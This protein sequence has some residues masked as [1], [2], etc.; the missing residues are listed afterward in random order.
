M[1]I[2]IVSIFYIVLTAFF[3]YLAIKEKELTEKLKIK[4][5]AFVDKVLYKMNI[6]SETIHNR[7]KQ[8]FQTVTVLVTAFLLVLVIQRF[9]IGNFNIPTGSMIPTIELKDRVFGNMVKYKFIDPK[10]NEII[11]FKEPIENKNLYTKRIMALPG[12]TIKIRND[13]LIVDDKE[14]ETRRYSNLGIEDRVWIVPKKGDVLKIV[15]SGDYAAVFSQ[16]GFDIAD[17]Q[18][19]LKDNAYAVMQ[20]LPNLKFYVNDVET[21]PIFDFIHDK[22]IFEK[23]IH[24]ETVTLTLEENYFLALGDNTDESFD[25]RFWGF[26]GK[27]RIRGEVLFRFWPL[28]RMGIV[29]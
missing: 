18:A 13:K 24:G 5:A 20:N 25:S 11:V 19:K 15:P 14:I 27:H 22:K 26:V 12:E 6:E 8:I 9:Y 2:I 17:V 3:I 4:K 23:I 29:R 28:N 10:R 1:N 21:G 7:A 16:Y